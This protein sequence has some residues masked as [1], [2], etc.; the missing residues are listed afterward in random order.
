MAIRRSTANERQ[1]PHC[2]YGTNI[3]EYYLLHEGKDERHRTLRNRTGTTVICKFAAFSIAEGQ[4]RR[5]L[6]LRC[7]VMRYTHLGFTVRPL[8]GHS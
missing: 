4:V 5:P 3:P 1:P 2:A 8:G 7:D 6:R